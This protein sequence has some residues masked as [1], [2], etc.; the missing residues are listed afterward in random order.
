[1]GGDDRYSRTALPR[2]AGSTS[3]GAR[4][5][6]CL[7]P[8][9]SPA[10]DEVEHRTSED[11]VELTTGVRADAVGVEDPQANV[12]HQDLVDVGRRG[13]VIVGP[14]DPVLEP[15]RRPKSAQRF[16]RAAEDLQLGT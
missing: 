8:E 5:T 14:S 7:D 4:A 2:V 15:D 13:P 10:C 6:N 1:M 3:F 12:F 11:L 16:E 9:Q